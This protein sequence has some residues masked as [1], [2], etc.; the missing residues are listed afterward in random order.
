MINLHTPSYISDDP[1]TPIKFSNQLSLMAVLPADYRNSLLEGNM[2][3]ID[4]CGVVEKLSNA[5]RG[6]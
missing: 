1:L 4:G 5:K 2:E 6:K 3:Y